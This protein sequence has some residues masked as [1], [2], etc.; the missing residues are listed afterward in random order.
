MGKSEL[1]RL[2]RIIPRGGQAFGQCRRCLQIPGK[3]LS[4][5]SRRMRWAGGPRRTASLTGHRERIVYKVFYHKVQPEAKP[6]R[7]ARLGGSEQRLW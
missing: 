7:D 3:G 5:W 4:V 1:I 2:V 6:S